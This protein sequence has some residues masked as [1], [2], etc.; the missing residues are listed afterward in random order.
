MESQED[1]M[2]SCMQGSCRMVIIQQTM[3]LLSQ[4]SVITFSAATQV[5][6]LSVQLQPR[7]SGPSLASMPFAREPL[8]SL[9]SHH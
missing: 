2:D 7:S 3:V 6:L 5:I 9:P 8:T 4:S 1:K